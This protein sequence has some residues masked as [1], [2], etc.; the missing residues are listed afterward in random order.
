MTGCRR[1]EAL[2][3]RW[4]D[5]DMEAGTISVR[6]ALVPVDGKVI[7][8][9]PK[10]AAGGAVSPWTPSRL[11]ALKAHAARQADEQCRVG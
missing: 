2:G 11:A 9:D 1:G 10:T 5:V 7:V 8:S 6:Q 4:E 3:L